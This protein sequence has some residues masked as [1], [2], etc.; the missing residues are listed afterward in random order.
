[1]TKKK[2]STYAV[3][4]DDIRNFLKCPRLFNQFKPST[5]PTPQ[6]QESITSCINR[7][8]MAEMRMG[9]LPE[10]KVVGTYWSRRLNSLRDAGILDTQKKVNSLRIALNNLYGL[11]RDKLF[12]K[13]YKTIAIKYPVLFM[14][15]RGM[16]SD[17]VPIV[18][19]K[20]AQV[21]PIFIHTPG[22]YPT[23]NNQIRFSIAALSE[24]L[25]TEI[26]EYGLIVPTDEY[27]NY[28]LENFKVTEASMAQIKEELKD[29]LFLM[30]SE[31]KAS[32]TD[33]C[34]HCEFIHKC[35]M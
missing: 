11:F 26:P 27:R 17:T 21:Y 33:H 16:Y 34:N 25:S 13:R 15:D 29:L 5:M 7:L 31:Y 22:L 24:T 19:H 9:Q 30:T 23:R 32:N 35:K 14:T 1:M 10:M 4:H 28:N 20:D 8:F 18:M 2:S 6:T 12:N 3:S